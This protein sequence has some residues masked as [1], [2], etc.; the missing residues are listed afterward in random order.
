M[1][2]LKRINFIFDEKGFNNY[3]KNVQKS[4]RVSTE[5][6]FKETISEVKTRM[7]SKANSAFNVKKKTFLNL[8]TAKFY[9]SKPEKL[10]S[11]IFYNK[12][13]YFDVF[14]KGD[15]VNKKTLIPF[16]DA[17]SK[18]RGKKFKQT[19]QTLFSFNLCFFK[20]TGSSVIL[21]ATVTK[22]SSSLLTPF[23]KNY[24][25]KNGVKTIKNGT[26][27]PIAVLVDKV[28]YKKQYDIKRIVDSYASEQLV[29]NIN[30]NMN[31]NRF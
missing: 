22:E 31:I 25:M 11:A 21:Y 28:K 30:K 16:V 23:K 3:K 27:I 5:I 10:P 20:K 29:K 18:M 14:I 13:K 4:I 7:K 19:V 26:T 6:A 12:A 15:T 2:D 17:N 9:N 1:I 8:F 24:R